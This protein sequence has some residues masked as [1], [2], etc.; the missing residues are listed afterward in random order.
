M[1]YL[2][3]EI[4]H[5]GETVDVADRRLLAAVSIVLTMFYDLSSLL[6][7][8]DVEVNAAASTNLPS[9]L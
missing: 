2:P 7:F 6:L 5:A 9:Q 1:G 4:P 3:A 8:P